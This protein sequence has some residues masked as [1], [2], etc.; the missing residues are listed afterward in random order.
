MYC[1]VPPLRPLETGKQVSKFGTFCVNKVQFVSEETTTNNNSSEHQ[2]KVCSHHRII[3]LK[4]MTN[5]Y[6]FVAA[7]GRY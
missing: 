6:S 4:A 7:T 3:R 2:N 5:L 1:M